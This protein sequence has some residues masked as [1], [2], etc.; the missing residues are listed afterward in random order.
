MT[1][2][3]NAGQQFKPGSI[4]A[5]REVMRQRV[6]R[7]AEHPSDEYLY[8]ESPVVNR[9]T[10]KSSG[11]VPH[12]SPIINS[13]PETGE[14]TYDERPAVFFH[15]DTKT[16]GEYTSQEGKAADIWA[17]KKGDI[18]VN[19]DDSEHGPF[20][21]QTVPAKKL[22]RVGHLSLGIHSALHDA[23][24][25]QEDCMECKQITG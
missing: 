25:P 1:S 24:T 12:V 3:E 11:L 15:W 20:A 6:E 22:T 10:I 21:E 18:K 17:V 2:P 14:E 8:H 13:D 4:E 5:F 23:W 16:I 9:G 7:G 19:E